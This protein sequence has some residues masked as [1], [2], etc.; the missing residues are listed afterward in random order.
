MTDSLDRLVLKYAD[1]QK[2]LKTFGDILQE[3]FSV[4]VRDATIQRF[5]YTFEAFWKFLKEYLK[6]KEGVVANTPKSV[7]REI[8]SLG[9]LTEEETVHFLE[10]T[11]RRN[12]TSHTYKEAVSQKIYE[13]VPAYQGLMERLLKKFQDRIA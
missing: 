2:A 12:E 11:D 8:F 6:V 1:A 5:E 7:F 4:L 9:L 3:P 10:M 13:A